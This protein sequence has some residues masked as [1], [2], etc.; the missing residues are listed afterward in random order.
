MEEPNHD[1]EYHDKKCEEEEI[2]LQEKVEKWWHD[3]NDLTYKRE[4][5]EEYYPDKGFLM[6][7]GEMWD[8]LRWLDKLDIY[9]EAEGFEVKI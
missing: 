2:K 8:G 5:V 1:L 4:L 9:N 3:V 6:D 7:V